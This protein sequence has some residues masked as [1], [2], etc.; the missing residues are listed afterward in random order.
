MAIL[1]SL[2]VS[3]LTP[4]ALVATGV[5]F[6]PFLLAT[7]SYYQYQ[8]EDPENRIQNVDKLLKY[9]DFIIVGAGSAGSVVANRLSENPKWKVLLVEAGGDETEISDVPALAAYLQLGR[10]DWKYKTEPQPGRACLGHSNQRCNWPRGKVLGGSSVLN[11][12]LY[13][14]GNK[15]DY[16]D[17]EAQ[18]NPGWGYNTVLHYFKKSED[19][20]NPYLAATPY[21]GTGGYLTVQEA[22]WRTPL[23]TAFVAAGVEMGYEN[24]DGNGEFQTGFMIPQGTIRRGSRCSTAKGFLRPIR[25]RKNLHI[26][27]ETMVLKILLDNH[28]TAIGVKLKRKDKIYSIL[29]KKEVILSAGALNS[30]QLLMLSGIG[31]ANHLTDL[32]IKVNQDLPV[33]ENLQDHYGTGALTFTLKYPISLVQTR[34]E[35]I[36]S[37]LKYA[38]F[39][40]GPLTVLGGVEGLAWVPTKFTNRS[41]DWPDIEFHFISGSLGSDGG[42]QIRKAHGISDS[43]WQMFRPLAYKDTWSVIPMLLRP[44]SRGRV[45][46]RSSNPYDKPLFYAGYFTHP[47][48]IKVLVEGV[49]IGLAMSQTKAF[50]N[51]GTEFWSKI[52]MP[53]CEHTNA[54]S[55]E[56]WECMC[57]HYTTTIYHHSGSAKM[58]PPEDPAAVTNH[59]LKV[60]GVPRLRVVDASIMPNIPSGNTNAPTIMI[61]EK[62]SDM[63]KADWGFHYNNHHKT[64]QRVRRTTSRGD[65]IQYWPVK[66]LRATNLTTVT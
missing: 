11:Y 55:D 63:I 44:K 37:V 29:A 10:M 24:R 35:N 1:P 43:M 32:G 53:G 56:Y 65:E 45:M 5:W 46:L 28:N 61:G 23:S 14:R 17:W 49:K 30:A 8:R 13:V 6:F 25:D 19:N 18:G 15:K 7:L 3:G 62:A 39:G 12:M 50:L 9:Y 21:H 22:P 58:G 26:T 33:G 66:S 54:W 59:E 4:T 20:R 27:T 51:L 31:P 36:P 34:Y 16:N 52:L 41:K 48:D 57:R 2:V 60:Y 47:D 40:T 64:K 42:R 38:V